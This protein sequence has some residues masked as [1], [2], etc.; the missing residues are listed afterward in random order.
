[1]PQHQRNMDDGFSVIF[2]HKI[3]GPMRSYF[4]FEGRRA[5]HLA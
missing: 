4:P 5:G 2:S 1:M 3:T